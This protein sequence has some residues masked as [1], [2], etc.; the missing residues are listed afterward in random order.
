MA[1]YA[2]KHGADGVFGVYR[3]R[4]IGGQICGA[5]VICWFCVFAFDAVIL[6][7][8]DRHNRVYRGYIRV[9]H[10]GLEKDPAKTDTS[11]VKRNAY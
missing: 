1:V 4:L 11:P 2:A 7:A 5:G 6:G 10:I 3:R 8:S 9:Y